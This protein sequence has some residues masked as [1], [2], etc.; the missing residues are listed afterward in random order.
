MLLGDL[1]ADVVKVERPGG[2]GFRSWGPKRGGD[3][4]A[5]L[6]L[7]RNKRSMTLDLKRPEDRAAA[8]QLALQMDIVVENF[9][10]GTMAKAGLAYEQLSELNPRLIYCSI[11]GYG[12]TGPLKDRGGFDLILQGYC[13]LMSVTG[14]AG[15]PPIKSGVP[16]IDF[17]AAAHAAIGILAA[18]LARAHSDRGQYIDVSL[19]DVPVSWLG[20]LAAKY[21]ATGEVPMA[22]GSAHPLSAPYQAFSTADGYITIAAGNQT[23]WTSTC[24]VLGLDHL[25]DDSRFADNDARAAHQAE[26]APLVEAALVSNTTAYWVEKMAMRG[27][28]CGPIYSVDQVL[29]DAQVLHR[30][31]VLELEDP[32]LGTI[33]MIGSPI[34]MSETP[35][36][37]RRAPPTLGQHTAEIAAEYGLTGL[38]PPPRPAAVAD[39]RNA[40]T[41]PE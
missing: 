11:S 15:G 37:V 12:Q 39:G 9:R 18:C 10:P 4:S 19:L 2:D 20:L 6:Q 26:L 40:G 30:Q 31:M 23:L 21:W 36:V 41:I 33:K 17:G 29:V 3:G 32:R 7:N 28:P 14:E 16:L 35:V 38:A 24:H 1:G 22:M 8:K 5:F 25:L 13:G 27:V 34:K